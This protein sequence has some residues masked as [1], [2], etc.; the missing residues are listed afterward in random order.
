MVEIVRN[1]AYSARYEAI[2]NC[3]RVFALVSVDENAFVLATT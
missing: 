3:E 2:L 1:G